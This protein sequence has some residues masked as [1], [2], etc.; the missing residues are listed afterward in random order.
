VASAAK[1][2]RRC[3]QELIELK[4]ASP[5]DSDAL[6]RALKRCEQARLAVK[7]AIRI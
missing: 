4:A 1:E 2:Y 6:R 3:K 7:Q 5:E